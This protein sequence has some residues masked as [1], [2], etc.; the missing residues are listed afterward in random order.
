MA[1]I[2]LG[3]AGLRNSDLLFGVAV[4]GGGVALIGHG[5]VVLWRYTTLSDRWSSLT[6][7]PTDD[8]PA[9]DAGRSA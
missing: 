1:L 6:R 5:I 8:P 4:I 2:G 9:S 7:G 3:I